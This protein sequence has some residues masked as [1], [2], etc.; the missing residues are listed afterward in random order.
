MRLPRA[1][2]ARLPNSNC[3]IAER[4]RSRGGSPRP[5]F[6][7]SF[8]LL[9]P[10][11]GAERHKA[12]RGRALARSTGPILPD[13]PRLTALHCGVFNPWGPTSSPDDSCPEGVRDNDPGLRS[14]PG[15]YRPRTP[16][17]TSAN[18]GRRRRS[19]FTS[20]TPAGRP[21]CEGGCAQD[22]RLQTAVKMKV[23][24]DDIYI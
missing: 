19:L 10:K 1:R 16:G 8:D 22:S 23:S 20:S 12:Q 15:G 6:V 4:H 2:R 24:Y 5:S 11:E 9:P 13:R 18:R 14:E 17:T 7:L 21:S 3:Q